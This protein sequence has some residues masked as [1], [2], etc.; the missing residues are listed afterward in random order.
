MTVTGLGDQ[1]SRQLLTRSHFEFSRPTVELFTVNRRKLEIKPLPGLSLSTVCTGDTPAVACT[2]IWLRSHSLTNLNQDMPGP[3]RS[4]PPRTDTGTLM[5]PEL[6]CH[7]SSESLSEAQA[8][9]RANRRNRQRQQRLRACGLSA[10]LRYHLGLVRRWRYLLGRVRVPSY[11]PCWGSGTLHVTRPDPPHCR[12]GSGSRR[13]GGGGRRE[14]ELT[15]EQW[16]PAQAGSS[17]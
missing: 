15:W 17:I 14:R 9:G 5:N 11:S 7:Q 4:F 1:G 10:V 2:M 12:L 8:R 16:L 3:G 13:R 6:R